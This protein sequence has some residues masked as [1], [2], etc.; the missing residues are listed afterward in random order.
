MV[1]T[2]DGAGVDDGAAVGSGTGCDVGL[3]VAVTVAMDPAET[4]ATIPVLEAMEE[5]SSGLVR[6]LVMFEVSEAVEVVSES[7]STAKDTSRDT[8]A[9]VRCAGPPS[10]DGSL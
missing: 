9:S 3:R 5:D 10:A 2:G 1:G 7:T 8:P 6:V 4:V